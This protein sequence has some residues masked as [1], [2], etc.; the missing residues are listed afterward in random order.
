MKRWTGC[1]HVLMV[2]VMG[3]KERLQ[4]WFVVANGIAVC[5]RIKISKLISNSFPSGSAN[6]PK[7]FDAP[8]SACK[9]VIVNRKTKL[10]Y[11]SRI[12]RDYVVTQCEPTDNPKYRSRNFCV[13][14]ATSQG[15]LMKRE[16]GENHEH[17]YKVLQ[18]MVPREI[19][20]SLL[21]I[22]ELSPDSIYI[23]TSVYHSRVHDSATL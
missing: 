3:F 4:I 15:S 12:K 20:F 21:A 17:I 14:S 8:N 5:C 19:Y 1:V 9:V 16:K 11:C 10:K 2:F 18:L 22:M 6:S 7:T 13:S 23:C